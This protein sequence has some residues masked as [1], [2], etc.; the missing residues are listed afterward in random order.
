MGNH[1]NERFSSE[2]YVYGKEPNAFVV[3]ALSKI[4]FGNVLCIAEGEGRNAVFLA[5]Q[6]REVTAW[7]YAEAGLEK[8]AQL[9]QEEQVKVTTRLC[10]LATVQWDQEKWDAIIHIFG[11][12]P[13]PIMQRT[14]EGVRQSLKV[15]GRYITELYTVEQL[16]YATGGPRDVELLCNPL[17]LLEAFQGE[18]IHHLFVGEVERV[19]GTLHTGTAHVVQAVIEKR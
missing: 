8:T 1:W 2:E 3:Q 4:P 12:V 13:T 16:A 10:D 5:K 17:Q 15:G 9:A 11:H 18:F 7:D 19:E 6:G 14:W